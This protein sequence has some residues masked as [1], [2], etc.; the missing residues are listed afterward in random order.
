MCFK[1]IQDVSELF[2]VI[3]P[4]TGQSL[5][6]TGGLLILAALGCSVP[7]LVVRRRVEQGGTVVQHLPWLRK[8]NFGLLA[9]T[10]LLLMLSLIVPAMNAARTAQSQAVAEGPWSEHSL[11]MLCFK[12]RHLR[13]GN[14]MPIHQSRTPR[15]G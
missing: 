7:A 8:V 15:F 10:V 6:G 2:G 9:V 5:A 3:A 4:S 14:S 12:C 13:I 11:P 1:G